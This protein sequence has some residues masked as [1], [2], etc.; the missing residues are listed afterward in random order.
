MKL[1]NLSVQCVQKIV[2]HVG[3]TA[4]ANF[5][6]ESIGMNRTTQFVMMYVLSKHMKMVSSANDVMLRV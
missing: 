4:N 2:L 1:L 6:G 5:A 3:M